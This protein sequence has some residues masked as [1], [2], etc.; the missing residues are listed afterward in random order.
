VSRR[1]QA[2]LDRYLAREADSQGELEPS[3]LELGFGFEEGDERGEPSE[4][5]AFELGGGV[6]LRGRIDRIDVGER[7]ETVVYDYKGKAPPGASKWIEDGKLQ[8]AL[9]MRVAEELLGLRVVGG[10]Y[11]PLTG[12]DLRPRG[13]LDGDSGLELDCFSTDVRD[14]DEVRELLDQ[15]VATAR[16]AAAEAAAGRLQARPDSCA[17]RGGCQF[18][19]ICRCER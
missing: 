17:F 16:E 10:F 11:Q 3:E 7:G 6:K 4:L 18:P 9:Y 12:E 8:V 1:L 14:H 13:V 2:D 19:T 15:A 5:G